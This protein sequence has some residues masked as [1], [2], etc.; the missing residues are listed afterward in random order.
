MG[1]SQLISR[2]GRKSTGRYRRLASSRTRSS[3]VPDLRLELRRT[4]A[5]EAHQMRVAAAE[6]G[7]AVPRDQ[8]LHAVVLALAAAAVE[9]LDRHDALERRLRLVVRAES[10]VGP[11]GMA[12]QRD[13]A[14]PRHLGDDLLRGQP[15]VGEVETRE[16]V[17]VDAVDEDVPVVG[18]HLGRRQ[19]AEAV[20][21][22]QR[23]IVAHEV[24]LPVL[25]QHDAVERPLVALPREEL[26]VR[27][28]GRAAV[29]RQLGV[30][31]Q[32]EDHG[33]GRNFGSVI[34]GVRSSNTTSTGMPMRTASG[35][36]PTTLDGMRT[37]SSSSTIAYTYG[38][39]SRKPGAWFWWVTV[40]V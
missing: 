2:F 8:V 6:R 3:V 24:E 30:E 31:V 9:G 28:D 14:E 40:Y 5:D 23:A 12:G 1:S 15:H 17:G 35:G 27:L 26:Q 38:S 11:A 4:E 34:S 13:A 29:V 10:H 33:T 19:D 37:P 16:D 36:Q 20:G 25:R 32:V 7:V 18:L 39:I 21:V 22:L